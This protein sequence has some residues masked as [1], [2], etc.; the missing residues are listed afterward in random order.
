MGS[1]AQK[2]FNLQGLCGSLH[3]SNKNYFYLHNSNSGDLH[4]L[5]SKDDSQI[6]MKVR[7]YFSTVRSH[8]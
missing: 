1:V 5:L 8:S 7:K 3:N 2:E 6:Q 4:A